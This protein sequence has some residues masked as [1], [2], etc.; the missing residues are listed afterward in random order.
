MKSDLLF[1]YEQIVPLVTFHYEY[2][3]MFVWLLPSL[4]IKK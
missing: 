3:E 2:L 4:Q 1:I